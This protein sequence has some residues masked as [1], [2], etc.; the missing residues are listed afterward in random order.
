VESPIAIEVK[1][2]NDSLTGITN[3]APSAGARKGAEHGV[4][5]TVARTPVKNE[6]LSPLFVCRPAPS[7]VAPSPN[8][9]T[10]LKFIAKTSKSTASPKTNSG[11]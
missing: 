10:P 7:P 1:I 11:D 9:K 4:A 2:K 8:S 3:A 6:P 5:T